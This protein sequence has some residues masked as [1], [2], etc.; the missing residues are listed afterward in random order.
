MNGKAIG[1]FIVGVALVMTGG[2][3]CKYVNLEAGVALIGIGGWLC[4]KMQQQPAF[5]KL[6]EEK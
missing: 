6:P 4:G 3:F 1:V 5:A 2:L